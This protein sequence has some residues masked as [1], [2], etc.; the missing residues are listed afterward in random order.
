MLSSKP[1]SSLNEN[2]FFEIFYLANFLKRLGRRDNAVDPKPKT[3]FYKFIRVKV[4]LKN[5]HINK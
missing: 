5:K 2:F 1:F 3:T 4:N